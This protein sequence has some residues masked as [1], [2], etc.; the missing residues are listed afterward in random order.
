MSLVVTGVGAKGGGGS[1]LTRLLLLGLNYFENLIINQGPI[2]V[3]PS[4]IIIKINENYIF[5]IIR[6][7]H[8]LTNE[9]HSFHR[10]TDTSDLK[11]FVMLM[12]MA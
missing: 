6:V 5:L 3:K 4:F 2:L 9:P 8:T 1:R 12:S 10:H 7:T 11:I